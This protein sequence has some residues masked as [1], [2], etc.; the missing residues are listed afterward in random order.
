MSCNILGMIKYLFLHHYECPIHCSSA[1]KIDND[2][3]FGT[4]TGHMIAQFIEEGSTY[5]YPE[6]GSYLISPHTKNKARLIYSVCMVWTDLYI[7]ETD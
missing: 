3:I 2:L 7:L 4:G 1:A 6:Y 5:I